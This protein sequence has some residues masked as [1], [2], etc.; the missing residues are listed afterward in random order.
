[1][2]DLLHRDFGGVLL[3]IHP[4]TENTLRPGWVNSLVGLM[5]KTLD[6]R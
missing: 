2:F 6:F 5:L 1:M 3:H 4:P